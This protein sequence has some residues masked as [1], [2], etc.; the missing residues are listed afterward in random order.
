VEYTSQ[1]ASLPW[2]SR[3]LGSVVSLSAVTES[4]DYSSLRL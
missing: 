4:Q 3:S 2:T 1:H